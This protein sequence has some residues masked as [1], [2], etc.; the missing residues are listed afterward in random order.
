MKMKTQRIFFPFQKIERR[1]N[2][3]LLEGYAFV[4]ERVAA[5]TANLK[6]SAMEAATAD[7][8]KFGAVREM[9]GP[10]AAGTATA[11]DC[12]VFWDD[13]GAL[14][15]ALIVDPVAIEKCETGVYKGFSVGVK[16]TIMR[17]SDVEQCIWAENSLVDRPAD[18]DAI[19][20]IARAEGIDPDEETE[21]QVLPADETPEGTE[22]AEP[23]VQRASFATAIAAQELGD[24]GYE[25]LDTL[26]NVLWNIAYSD[27]EDPEAEA[28]ASIQEFADY[29]VPLVAA[30][31]L[32]QRSETPDAN[33]LTV[34]EET[35]N[36]VSRALKS[37]YPET[38]LSVEEQVQNL[39][40]T[41][42]QTPGDEPE[43]DPAPD[44]QRSEDGTEPGTQNSEPGTPDTVTR[45]ENTSNPEL[46]EVTRSL[47]TLVQ[48][49]GAA[50]ETIRQLKDQPAPV[51][52]VVRN[53]QGIDRAFLANEEGSSKD[54]SDIERL[55]KEYQDVKKA[56]HTESHEGKKTQLVSRMI[57][58]NA[59]LEAEYGVTAE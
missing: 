21:V 40:A 11:E 27:C 28:R 50:E 16:P 22:L 5:D 24:K 29:L 19:F 4:N 38:D 12:G 52:P 8:M 15:R 2:H 56:M 32:T 42:L 9:H 47:Q 3:L 58:I 7:Y 44:T 25:A 1:G 26:Y 53:T 31:S 55:R 14:L 30:K 37:L 51:M 33:R 35:L 36:G 43:A 46:A 57:S 17:G 45:A 54:S 10:N 48:R 23:P 41:A 6:R 39:V 49:L 20:Q 18:P 59:T 13:K 34:L